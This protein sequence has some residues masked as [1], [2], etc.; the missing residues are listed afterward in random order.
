M[1][2]CGGIACCLLKQ[3]LFIEARAAQVMHC[4]H[5]HAPSYQCRPDARG[6]VNLALTHGA[7]VPGIMRGAGRQLLATISNAVVYWAGCCPLAVLLAPR[8]GVP[9]LWLALAAAT[10]LQVL[11]A[12]RFCRRASASLFMGLAL[13]SVPGTSCIAG[14]LHC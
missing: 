6:A 7:A 12:S 3:K 5:A 13:L 10:T 14:W 9:G 8:L 1:R 2:P 11:T 4:L